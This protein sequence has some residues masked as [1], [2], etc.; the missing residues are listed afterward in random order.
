[1]TAHTDIVSGKGIKPVIGGLRPFVFDGEIIPLIGGG[2]VVREM[3]CRTPG[4][5][6][7]GIL[8]IVFVPHVAP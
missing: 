1:M 7:C 5:M 4:A 8:L 3:A 2:I 6:A